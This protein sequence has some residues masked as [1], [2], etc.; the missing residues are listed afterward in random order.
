[1]KKPIGKCPLEIPG[2]RGKINKK[3]D[4]KSKC[5]GKAWTVFIWFR[6]GARGGLFGHGN[7]DWLPQNARNFFAS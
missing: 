6:T 4:L 7:K 5:D 2:R 3:I 1:M